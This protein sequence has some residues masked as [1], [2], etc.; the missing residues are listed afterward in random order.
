MQIVRCRRL[1]TWV[2]FEVLDA[3]LLM[4]NQIS[5]PSCPSSITLPSLFSPKKGVRMSALSS[6]TE[7]VEF[8]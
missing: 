5:L 8:P 3:D 2:D 4:M 1:F 7:L 6:P